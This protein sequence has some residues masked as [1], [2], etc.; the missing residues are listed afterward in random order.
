[1]TD[2]YTEIKVNDELLEM[3]RIA[4]ATAGF[5]EPVVDTIVILPWEK[6]G[7]GLFIHWQK[8]QTKK[9]SITQ[10]YLV[11]QTAVAPKALYS[12]IKRN[13]IEV[14]YKR[15]NLPLPKPLSDEGKDLYGAQLDWEHDA[16]IDYSESIGIKVDYL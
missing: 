16:I 14:V 6:N 12:D 5:P 3:V 10:F 11:R 15:W 9:R 4:A 8:F 13:F 7:Y 2:E 1:M